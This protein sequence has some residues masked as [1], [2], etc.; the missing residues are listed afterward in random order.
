MRYL[1]ITL[2]LTASVLAAGCGDTAN[3]SGSSKTTSSKSNKTERTN[4]EAK[5]KL[6]SAT[7]SDPVGDQRDENDRPSPAS[8][9]L[10]ITRISAKA[11]KGDTR[12]YRFRVETAAAPQ[13]D[14][15]Y[16]IGIYSPDGNHGSLVELRNHGPSDY[17]ATIFNM[18]TNKQEPLSE[19]V[20]F[21]DRSIEIDV[22]ADSLLSGE[23]FGFTVTVATTGATVETKDV[24][25]DPGNA[26]APALLRVG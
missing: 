18:D 3:S 11:R 23:P 15:I 4:P 21:G 10:D 20:E 5:P 7:A 19:H 26:A 24:A 12:V 22:P 14:T 1:P 2:L 6:P 8:K 16:Q 25:P 9:F 17:D 13:A